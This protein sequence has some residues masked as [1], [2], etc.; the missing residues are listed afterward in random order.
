LSAHTDPVNTLFAFCLGE[1]VL[2]QFHVDLAAS[3]GDSCLQPET[4]FECVVSAQFDGA[5]GASTRCQGSPTASRSA[6]TTWRAAPGN[7]AAFAT[8][9]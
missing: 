2:V 3:E 4:L 7:P 6:A 5:S 9:P 1:F 8:A